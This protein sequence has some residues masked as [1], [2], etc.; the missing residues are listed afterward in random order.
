M[1]NPS[2]KETAPRDFP[3]RSCKHRFSS[4]GPYIVNPLFTKHE[5]KMAAE[6]VGLVFFSSLTFSCHLDFALVYKLNSQKNRKSF[7]N[8][9]PTGHLILNH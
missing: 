2:E 4:F 7:I 6:I 1:D 9:Q 8:I 5:V 3:R